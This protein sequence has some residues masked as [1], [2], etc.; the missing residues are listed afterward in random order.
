[1]P[2]LFFADLVRE[3]CH[4]GGAGALTPA[5]ALPGHRAFADAVPADTSF[6]YAIA[7]IAF[8][9]EWE[10][11]TGR[12]DGAGRLVRDSIAASSSGGAAV[13]FTPGLKT[14]ALTVGADWFAARDAGAAAL[15]A[16]LDGKQPLSTLHADAAT[17]A[18]GDLITVRRA[19]GWVNVPIASFAYR[20]AGG[21]VTVGGP[22]GAQSGSAAAPSIS[23]AS[24]LDSGLFCAAPNVVGLA[25]G[26]AERVRIDAAG[27]VG[28]GAPA[29]AASLHVVSPAGRRTAI[30]DSASAATDEERAL[31]FHIGGTH[32][33]SITVPV[34]SGGAIAFCTG[35]GLAGTVA[36]RVRI[37][38]NGHVRPAADN[39]QTL[40]QASY[41][42]SVAYAGTGSINTSDARDK[43]WRGAPSLAETAAARRIAEGLGFYQWNDAIA[44]KGADGARRHFGV[45]AQAAWAIMADEGLVD[46]IGDDGC[47][48]ATPYA[49]LCWDAWDEERDAAG[50]VVRAP[51]DRFGIRP[52]QLALFL[53]AGLETR[54]AALEA[55]A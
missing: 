20:E 42:W 41:R 17:G 33:A 3:H 52:D 32:F 19:E 47:P 37:G 28:I 29:P 39:A 44:A 21:A 12:I 15:E 16:A 10:V 54:I 18:A 45:R 7:G 48:G 14:L 2:S 13:D 51:G 34:G 50:D 1:M 8:A 5:G 36:E 24:D 22:L 35:N 49:F 30:L 40:G 26:G 4:E 27:N 6:H 25:T 55:A 38:P 31:R 9:D 46:P 11:G 43:T 23:F 53:I